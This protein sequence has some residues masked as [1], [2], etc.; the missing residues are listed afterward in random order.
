MSSCPI[1]L[2][3]IKNKFKTDCCKQSFCYK[4]YFK[5]CVTTGSCPLC[6]N[7]TH[8]KN[9]AK[10]FDIIVKDV[11]NHNSN[12]MPA[13]GAS[14]IKIKLFNKIIDFYRENDFLLDFNEV[15]EYLQKEYFEIKCQ[16]NWGEWKEFDKFMSDY[17]LDCNYY[18]LDMIN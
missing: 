11:Q 7:E 14:R 15:K 3:D 8:A 1:C 17:N 2:D 4:C 6:R 13:F 10:S 16:I 12:R 5:S 9:L 18:V